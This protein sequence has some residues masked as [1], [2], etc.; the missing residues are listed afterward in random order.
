MLASDNF[1]KDARE[2]VNPLSR[3]QARALRRVTA[4]CDEAISLIRQGE[5]PRPADMFFTDG[6]Q[7][8]DYEGQ[9]PWG[10]FFSL[11]RSVSPVLRERF[12]ALPIETRRDLRWTL[13]KLLS[14]RLPLGP[15]WRA[16][17]VQTLTNRYGTSLLAVPVA[18]SLSAYLYAKWDTVAALTLGPPLPVE[19]PREVGCWFAPLGFQPTK[20]GR[21]YKKFEDE[22]RYVVSDFNL[23]RRAPTEL[24]EV[25][26]D[27]VAP[28]GAPY[29]WA[30][31]CSAQSAVEWLRFVLQ[32]TN[33]PKDRFQL[34]VPEIDRF[35]GV[36]AQLR[37]SI[38]FTEAC[39][40]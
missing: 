14:T 16:R 23:A 33:R 27:L 12:L 35:N 25:R 28:D 22:T 21:V 24:G 26:I 11:F 10:D 39:A 29:D 38:W 8:E 32:E 7:C 6:G 40:G 36:D 34:L 3:N 17:R 18:P 31:F 15:R 4:D 19:N 30:G 5:W 9:Q 37:M 2:K 1:D 20:E 13:V